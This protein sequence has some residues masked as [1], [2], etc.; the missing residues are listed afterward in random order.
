MTWSVGP[1]CNK[2]K[3]MMWSLAELDAGFQGYGYAG[4][5]PMD[6]MDG[7]MMH[8]DYAASM[9]YD[10]QVYPPEYWP[11]GQYMQTL[12]QPIII[13]WLKF[14]SP[15]NLVMNPHFF[16]S[17]T[18]NI[19]DWIRSNLTTTSFFL[20]WDCVDVLWSDFIDDGLET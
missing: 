15:E 11:E 5:I 17:R 6:G 10:R 4:D 14:K 1:V 2:K 19:D 3:Q 12:P 9:A 16:F 13:C 7:N 8:D 18:L 20:S